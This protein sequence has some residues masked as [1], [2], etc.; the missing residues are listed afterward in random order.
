MAKPVSVTFLGGLGEIG[1][2][3]AAIEVDG[4]IMLLD[5]GLMFPDADMLGIDLVLPDLSWLKARAKDIVGCVVTHGHED[6]HGALAYALRDL[7]FP[8]IGSALT[9]GFASNR[10]DEAGLMDRT[11]LIVVRDGE[12]RK[13]GPFDLEFIPVTHSVPH[14]FATAFHTPQGTILHTGD[15]KLDLTPVDGRLTDLAVMGAIA[16]NE[17]VRLLLSDSTNADQHGHSRSEKSVGKV[18]T[19]LMAA[20]AGR[21]VVT[22]CFASH[23]H[24]VQQIAD[25]AIAQGRVVAT[26]GL[27]MKKNVRLAKEMGLLKIPDDKLLDI[28]DVKDLEPGKV[29]V[30]ST[31]SQGEPM[32]ALAL[33]ASA[34]SRWLTLDEHD[35]VILSSHPIP[36]N[37]MNVS[38]VID[39][40]VRLGV[41]V[42]HSG[43]EDVH[44][45]G[46]AKQEELKTLLSIVRPEWFV[47]VHGEYR[48]LVAH[49][50]LARV[51]GVADSNVLI[52]EDGD[53][54][55]LSDKGLARTGR[56]P[57]SY[58]YVDGIVGDVGH[59]VIRDRK[60]LAE[61]GVVVVI[62]T[63]DHDT[64]E[65][66]TGPEVIT[67]GWIY[68]A[69]AEDLL[70]EMRGVIAQQLL[71]ALGK[72]DSDVE[73]LQRIV[74]KAAG[75]FVSDRTK[76]R[77]MIVPVVMSL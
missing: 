4:K 53:K 20:N 71:S 63:V 62:A 64:G 48:H 29:C 14:G 8:I 40:L 15:W 27:S 42:V 49:A 47:P 33:M 3:C 72:G 75:K 50:E 45:T 55:T 46:H 13:F 23:V 41:R 65:M 43:I 18:L 7:S 77:P 24:R 59:G 31:G 51:M 17:G 16:Q 56:V 73:S 57:A 39:G 25:A 70:D 69:E 12:R 1:R 38:K 67:R 66:V 30:I 26:L 21:R 11:E 58:V 2:N 9:L 37:E 28:E 34:E 32:S 60:V 35:T 44:A 74:R 76:R 22:A 5:C 52:C 54:V 6:H 19:D 10:I 68:A 61:E 36:G